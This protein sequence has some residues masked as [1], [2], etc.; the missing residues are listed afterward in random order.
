M[1]LPPA[2]GP[3]LLRHRAIAAARIGRTRSLAETTLFHDTADGVLGE[4]GL[5]IAVETTGRAHRQRLERLWPREAERFDPGLAPPVLAQQ[6]LGG[7][8]P[9][10]ALLEERL[11]DGSGIP[12]LTVPLTAI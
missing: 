6:R 1:T 2:S 10:V 11:P 12:P 5:T 3:A 4:A 8:T 9:D 7:A